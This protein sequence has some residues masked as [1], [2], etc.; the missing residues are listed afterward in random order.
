MSASRI[1]SR[2]APF[3]SR[4]IAHGR[5]TNPG[6]SGIL[7]IS[8]VEGK[9]SPDLSNMHTVGGEGGSGPGPKGRCKP[10]QAYHNPRHRGFAVRDSHH[11]N[12]PTGGVFWQ[13]R[14]CDGT[15]HLLSR[16]YRRR[17]GRQYL[18]RVDTRRANKRPRRKGST[19]HDAIAATRRARVVVARRRRDWRIAGH[20]ASASADPT[21][22]AA[23]DRF[24][25]EAAVDARQRSHLGP[26]P[27]GIS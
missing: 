5:A 1:C 21:M 4:S 24:L 26:R 12:R 17:V 2:R 3:L 9:A 22:R 8:A 11:R 16:S 14:P 10:T 23:Y 27:G 7:K 20:K 13:C 25:A 15:W 18:A 19:S 6:R